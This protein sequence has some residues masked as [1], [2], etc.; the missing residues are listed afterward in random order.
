ML[1]DPVNPGTNKGLCK[2]SPVLIPK[3]TWEKFANCAESSREGPLTTQIAP[4]V[5]VGVA[6]ANVAVF[7]EIEL[8][9]V[10]WSCTIFALE[11]V[12]KARIVNSA[13]VVLIIFLIPHARSWP[14]G[15]A[16]VIRI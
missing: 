15:P 5:E 2:A 4:V 6:T 11:T 9:V 3:E 8:N 7:P 12:V 13:L 14:P 10:T 16:P 1:D